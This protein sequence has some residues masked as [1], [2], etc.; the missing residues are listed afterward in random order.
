MDAIYGNNQKSRDTATLSPT[1]LN[2][3]ATKCRNSKQTEIN[4]RW[5]KC[6][7][8]PAQQNNKKLKIA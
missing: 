4:G 1:T 6:T 2:G 8:Q 7:N 3:H 5:A